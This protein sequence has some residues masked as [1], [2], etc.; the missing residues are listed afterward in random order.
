MEDFKDLFQHMLEYRILVCRTRHFAPVPD[1]IPRPERSP[2]SSVRAAAK[3]Y[4][5]Q[6]A[7]TVRLRPKSTGGRL[8]EGLLGPY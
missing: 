1:Y 3:R 8:S 4:Y 5:G 2:P 7:V 6:G